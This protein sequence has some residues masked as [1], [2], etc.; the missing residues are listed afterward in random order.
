MR[1]LLR[2]VL[3]SEPAGSEKTAGKNVPAGMAYVRVTKMLGLTDDA[4][5]DIILFSLHGFCAAHCSTSL[6]A[7]VTSS[8]C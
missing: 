4:L 8:F 2:T 3:E 1:I 6:P 5:H 7:H